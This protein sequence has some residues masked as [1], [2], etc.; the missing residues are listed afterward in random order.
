MIRAWQLRHFGGLLTPRFLWHNVF[1]HGPRETW[2]PS[3]FTVGLYQCRCGGVLAD[4][5]EMVT[6]KAQT[7]KQ[8]TEFLAAFRRGK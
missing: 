8:V 4:E 3:K 7:E 6:G 2:K 5:E 1:G